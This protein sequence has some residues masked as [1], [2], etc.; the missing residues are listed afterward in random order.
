MSKIMILTDSGADIP[1]EI[2]DELGITVISFDVSFDGENFKEL[3]KPI[4]EFY[5]MM[6]KSDGIPKTFPLYSEEFYKVYQKLYN[7]GYTD[8]ITVLI[9]SK[10]SETF[11]SSLKAKKLFYERSPKAEMRIFSID[12][13]CYSMSYG[14]AVIQAAKMVKDGADANQI[15]SY[16]EEWF[17][18]CAIYVV[19]KTLKYAKKSGRISGAVATIGD[20]FRIKPV[21]QFADSTSVTVDKIIGDRNV[22][23]KLVDLV[24]PR[25][26]ND[27][28]YV[29]IHGNNYN[30]AQEIEKHIFKRTGKEAAMYARI[31]CVVSANIGP[32]MVGVVI[33]RKR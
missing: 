24:V 2:I 22:V 12:S 8:V 6:N 30:F 27:S 13:H 9:N 7:E 14:Y 19:P 11:E 28:P 4:L 17:N 3:D 5:D 32:D 16:L 25:M 1:K 21:I 15:V 23:D 18:Y 31:G 20:L 26:A 29:I 33:K 10:G